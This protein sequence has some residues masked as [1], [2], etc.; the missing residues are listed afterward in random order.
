MKPSADVMVSGFGMWML[1]ICMLG[2]SGLL[3]GSESVAGRGWISVWLFWGLVG[4]IDGGFAFVLVKWYIY[5]SR[6]K[7]K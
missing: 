7:E 2:Q 3:Q 5:I 6:F 1:R 4:V